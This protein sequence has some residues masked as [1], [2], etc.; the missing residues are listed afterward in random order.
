VSA[1]RVE[2]SF[3]EEL[4][5]VGLGNTMVLIELEVPWLSIGFLPSGAIV[6]P[7]HLQRSG[8]RVD[9]T[10]ATTGGDSDLGPSFSAIRRQS[11]A[12]IGP[13]VAYAST[14]RQKPSFGDDGAVHIGPVGLAWDHPQGSRTRGN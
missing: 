9:V 1:G 4:D 2:V 14:P 13:A 6:C 8:V 7:H 11:V 5:C 10:G 12:P 3:A